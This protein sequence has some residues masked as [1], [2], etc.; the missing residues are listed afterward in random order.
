MG[1]DVGV[2]NVNFFFMMRCF[3]IH[4]AAICYWYVKENT[5]RKQCITCWT[6]ST[7]TLW[8][9]LHVEILCHVWPQPVKFQNLIYAR[10]VQWGQVRC[11]CCLRLIVGLASIHQAAGGWKTTFSL[12]LKFPALLS[13]YLWIQ[14]HSPMPGVVHV[15]Q[16]VPLD[17][18]ASR[19]SLWWLLACGIISQLSNTEPVLTSIDSEIISEKRI[20]KN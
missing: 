10:V 11:Q 16:V 18:L 17:F 2:S 4:N 13:P 7:P 3:P 12:F 1:S 14:D 6:S 15:L 20:N 5:S 9:H 19:C 8:W